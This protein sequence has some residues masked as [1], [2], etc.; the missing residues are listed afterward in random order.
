MDD[1]AGIRTDRV[2]MQARFVADPL[3]ND[4]HLT[5]TGRGHTMRGMR[6]SFPPSNFKTS[7]LKPLPEHLD[8]EPTVSLSD[9]Y[10]TTTGTTHDY[11]RH[12]TNLQQ[13]LHKKAAGS[14]KVHYNYNFLQKLDEKPWRKPLTMGEQCSEC[15]DQYRGMN[16][17]PGIHD[18]PMF[19]KGL[20][21]PTLK[22]QYVKGTTREIIPSSEN[23]SLKG[24]RFVVR[25]IG[26]LHCNEPYLSTTHKDHHPF[27]KSQLSGYPEKNVATYWQ[28]ED[29]PKAWG[30]GMRHNP[31]PKKKSSS[32]PE[33]PLR[34]KTFFETATNIP[35][36]SQKPPRV[37]HRG[38]EPLYTDSYKWPSE[39]KVKELFLCSV[40]KPF[41][42]AEPSVD[43][44]MVVPNMYQTF[45]TEYGKRL[46]EEARTV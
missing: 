30:H 34:D 24:D 13:P 7:R 25:D 33:I 45:N 43:D 39:D 9:F 36:L 18:Q 42:D 8:V 38:I 31:L 28:C 40:P 27:S 12:D 20:Q 5:S 17:L 16:T 14:W 32:Q 29:Y 19:S 37:P 1:E 26:A 23:Y 22:D 6:C 11:K 4:L 3:R 21:P 35:P 15:K 46:Q 41:T 10:R 44:V 2:R